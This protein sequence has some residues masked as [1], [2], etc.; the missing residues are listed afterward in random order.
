[1]PRSAA[2]EKDVEPKLLKLS[3]EEG[4]RESFKI[5]CR[6]KWNQDGEIESWRIKELKV[7]LNLMHG[8]SEEKGLKVGKVYSVSRLL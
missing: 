4:L 3:E 2:R 7:I 5:K 6:G 1:M 8:Y